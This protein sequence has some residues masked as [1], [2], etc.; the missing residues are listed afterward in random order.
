MP[1]YVMADFADRLRIAQ[2][3]YWL[4]DG[5]LRQA[6]TRGGAIVRAENGARLWQGSVSLAPHYPH[7]LREVGALLALLQEA[8]AQFN[9]DDDFAQSP[10]WDA[11]GTAIA[12]ATPR[13]GAIAGDGRT[14]GITDLPTGYRLS[15]GDR[16]SFS[17]GSSP[18]RIAL[19]EITT[20]HTASAGGSVSNVRVVPALRPGAATGA[21]IDFRRPYCRAVLVP[22]SVRPLSR[23]RGIAQGAAF[24]WLQV[25]S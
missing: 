9:L 18:T 11:G 4:G 16:F 24:D 1:T 10:R 8:D 25:L 2:D 23:A 22:G 21:V 7:A 14:C 13:L 15:P 3:T 17:Y 19:H 6:R 20:S 5:E 12:S